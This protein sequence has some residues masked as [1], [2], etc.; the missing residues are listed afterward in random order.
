MITKSD[1]MIFA[2]C[3]K[4]YWLSKNRKDLEKPIS[5]DARKHI[6]DGIKV[7]ALARQFIDNTFVATRKKTN[8]ELDIGAQ[9][10][11]TKLAM[12]ENFPC[13][14]EASFQVDDLFCA[15]D[16]L[17]KDTNGG[18]SILEVKATN[19]VKE[20]HFEDIAFQKY[21]LEKA[22]IHI[23]ALYILHLNHAYERHGDIDPKALLIADEVT[24]DKEVTDTLTNLEY[25]LDQMR[26]I[27]KEKD[28]FE[29]DLGPCCKDCPFHEYCHKDIPVPT[30][31]NINGVRKSK[32]Y[33]F[34]NDKIYSFADLLAHG[35]VPSNYRQQVQIDSEIT[36]KSPIIKDLEIN[37]F[38]KKIKYPLYHL[39]FE[40]MNEAIP[41][42]DGSHSYDQVPFQ[43]SLHIE[44]SAGGELEHREFLGDKLDC[45]R[46]L[47]EQLCHDIPVDGTPIAYNM[48]FEK[49]VL[50]HLAEQY[51]DLSEHLLAIR[52]NMI[53]LLVPF[54]SGAYYDRAQG[55]SN[56]IK[57]V[58]PALCPEMAEAYHELPVVH[59]GGE[60]L[61]MFP[62]MVKM[63]GTEYEETRKGMLMYCCLD[64]LSMVKVLNKLWEMSK[65]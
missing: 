10:E 48:T 11:A 50:K 52:E 35:F 57:Y 25:F 21:V 3:P 58:M 47:A 42:V 19:E 13:I 24:N 31:L 26:D 46:E 5:D 62:K 51:P 45:Q 29:Q 30:A 61:A 55:G 43:Y 12:R 63:T 9:I 6:E 8:G 54:K 44:K 27:Q 49:T 20:D 23:N 59:N 17:K 22:G 18:Y 16:L 38:L 60:A 36:G 28:E 56:S 65:K 32:A 1:F 4:Q 2:N 39:D 40:T 33:K 7:G 34:I 37:Q 53:D 15:V 64:T 14:A 41:P